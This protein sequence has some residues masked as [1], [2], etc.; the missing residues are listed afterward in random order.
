M[1]TK[2]H[3]I[4]FGVFTK[5]VIPT[6]AKYLLFSCCFH[7]TR[8]SDND[9]DG[10]APPTAVKK[11]TQ[12]Y[13]VADLEHPLAHNQVICLTLMMKCINGFALNLYRRWGGEYVLW[14]LRWIP[15]HWNVLS[16]IFENRITSF[17]A[18]K[19]RK[20]CGI[21]DIIWK[22][23][24]ILYQTESSAFSWIYGILNLKMWNAWFRAA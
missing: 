8:E 24:P 22:C 6:E 17:S 18:N 19:N 7:S 21:I 1:A 23:W 4:A 15:C 3:Y 12:V 11:P 20:W 9:D 5:I 2:K 16:I 14:K 13:L 10:A